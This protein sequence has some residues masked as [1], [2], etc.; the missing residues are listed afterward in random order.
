M[1]PIDWGIVPVKGRLVLLTAEDIFNEQP[2]MMAD[3][4]DTHALFHLKTKR[5]LGL[6]LK[7]GIRLCKFGADLV[8]GYWFVP[9][10]DTLK[11]V[12]VRLE[13][14]SLEIIK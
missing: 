8:N 12:S 1:K 13:D 7:R 10:D 6:S 2:M 3:F 9:E 11:N 14:L 5:W 4:K